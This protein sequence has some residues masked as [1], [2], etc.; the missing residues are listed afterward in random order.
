MV[1]AT[2]LLIATLLAGTA[3]GASAAVDTTDYDRLRILPALTGNPG[4][5]DWRARGAVTPV[6]NEGDCDASWAFGVAELVESDHAIRQGTLLSL[7]TQELLDCTGSESGCSGGRPISALR[8]VITTGGLATTASYPY[9]ARM[10]VCR[11]STPAATVPGAG[12][13]PPGDEASLQNYVARGPVLALIDDSNPAFNTYRGGIFTGPC[14]SGPP[15]RAV[16]IVGYTSDYWIVKNSL[17]TSWG[18]QGYIYMARHQNICGINNYAL[19]ISNDALPAP[20]VPAIPALSPWAVASLLG[21]LLAL[22]LAL[23]RVEEFR[24]NRRTSTP[25]NRPK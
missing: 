17:G 4:D 5:Q 23:S 6:K 22:G 8:T 1:I 10:G 3:L 2:R 15:T 12:L 19:A 14:G 13:V 24:S 21:S 7:S 11:A 25:M 20:A 9:T 18:A 16:L